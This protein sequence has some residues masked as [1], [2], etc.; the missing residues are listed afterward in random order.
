VDL[1]TLERRIADRGRGG[2]RPV[3]PDIVIANVAAETDP[4]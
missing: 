2:V 4:G 1:P 3:V